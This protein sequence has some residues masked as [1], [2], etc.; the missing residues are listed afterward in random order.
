VREA[1]GGKERYTLLS[2]TLLETLRRYYKLYRPGRWL[3]Y[4]ASKDKPIH[5]RTVQ[6]LIT[7]AGRKAGLTKK[8]TPHTLRHSF[9]THLLEHGTE[10]PYIQQLLGH[11]NLK[12]TLI[13]THVSSEALG[14]VVSPLD[15][16]LLPPLEPGS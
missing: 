7:A 14:R 4:C 11:R 6:K 12:S 13:Y 5:E 8:I 2:P 16:L 10:L 1:K 3:F 15:R 9:A